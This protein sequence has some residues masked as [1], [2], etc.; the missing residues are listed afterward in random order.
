MLGANDLPMLQLSALPPASSVAVV[1]ARMVTDL[2]CT[3]FP[4]WL[5]SFPWLRQL[6]LVPDISLG[7]NLDWWLYIYS[8]HAVPDNRPTASKYCW[9]FFEVFVYT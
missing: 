8:A 9:T 1:K 6:G 2:A 4:V 7:N 3:L 5:A